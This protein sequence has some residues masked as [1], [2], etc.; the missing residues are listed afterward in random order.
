MYT[1]AAAAAGDTTP[2]S[3]APCATS[4]TVTTTTA[5]LHWRS[6]MTATTPRGSSGVHTFVLLEDA[7]LVRSIP[8]I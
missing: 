7:G 3:A 5:R 1:A 8:T 6:V 2:L 4:T